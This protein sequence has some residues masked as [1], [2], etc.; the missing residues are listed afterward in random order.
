MDINK[1]RAD[2]PVLSRKIHGKDLI[3]FD[4]GATTQKPQVVIDAVSQFYSI[5]YANIHRGVH[6]LSN[7]ST[8]LYERARSTVK[9]FIGAAKLSEVI[10][11]S[12]TTSAI[13]LVANSFGEKYIQ[14]D[15]E[16]IISEMEH[17]ANIVSWQLLCERKGAKIKVLPFDEK[18]ELCIDLLDGLINSRTRILCVTQT[19][20]VLG[21]IN[22]LKEIIA[23]AH[24]YN[25]P[26]MVDGAQG[27][28]HAVIDVQDLDCDFYAF[29]GHKI[30]GPTGIGVLY[31][32]EKWLDEMPPWQGGGDMV[33]RVSFEKTTYAD[34]PLKFEAGT[35]NFVDAHGLAIALNYLKE[36]GT[37]QIVEYEKTLNTY[38]EVQLSKIENLRSFGKSKNKVGI[39]SFL[40]E[41]IHAL[42]TGMLLDK[43]GIA[44]RTGHLCANPIMQHYGIEGLV[45]ASWVFYNT[46]EEIDIFCDSL[47]KIQKLFT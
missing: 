21:T 33:K 45:R 13:N 34:L 41:G 25:I 18:G 10:F 37:E 40:M 7:L 46:K 5:D 15:D 2:F 12:G 38:A 16:I 44:V 19:S 1:I 28:Q 47:R 42:D 39:A 6:Y 22:P 17:H 32:K 35:A 8:E 36:L 23:K 4:N 14:R 9:E 29:S 24:A 20:N 31:G 11:T 27:V 43:M 26:V 3:Y 30:Y